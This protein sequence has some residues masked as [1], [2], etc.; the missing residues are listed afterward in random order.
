MNSAACLPHI[1]HATK[2]ECVGL[3]QLQNPAVRFGT[4]Y[5]MAQRGTRRF[6]AREEL[7]PRDMKGVLRNISLA[8]VLDGDFLYRVVGDATVRAY[9]LPLQNRRVSELTLEAPLLG[10]ALHELL[11]RVARSGEP[12]AIRGHIG[13]DGAH[14]NFT[15]FENALLPLGADHQT[16][17]H[18]LTVSTY[19]MRASRT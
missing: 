4:A 6:P 9:S 13:R 19:T 15:D 16:V 18:I 10:R 7:R 17:D 14:V 2:Y 8:K 12:L 5:W 11:G 3:D 1:R